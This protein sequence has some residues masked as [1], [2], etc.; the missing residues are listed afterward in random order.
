MSIEYFQSALFAAEMDA[1]W[2]NSVRSDKDQD[3]SET[4]K[5]QARDNI[6]AASFGSMLTILGHYN[7][8]EALQ[9]NGEQ[10]VGNA[11]SVGASVPYKLYIFDGMTESWLDY[12][13]IRS[14]DINARCVQNVAIAKSAWS[15]DTTA[16][17]G[18]SYKARITLADSTVDSFP[19]VVFESEQAFSGNFAPMSFAFA[20][21]LEVFAK[22]T[23][24]KDINIVTATVIVGGGAGKGITNASATIADKSI[25]RSMLANDA[26]SSTVKWVTTSP[27]TVIADDLEKTIV[28][29]GNLDTVQI[30]ISKS[31]FDALPTGWA[32]AFMQWSGANT[33]K[34]TITVDSSLYISKAGEKSGTLGGS[35]ITNNSRVMIVAKRIT[36]QSL[37]IFGIT[38]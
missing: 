29:D 13:Y 22:S 14:Q 31:L 28:F 26:L 3:L 17:S 5:A 6:G 34:L 11:Y 27:Y 4:Q 35:V 2:L 19:I 38:D 10:K 36:S 15:Q 7:T 16:L 12:G 8:V 9:A 23:P 21:Y 33:T 37:V 32:V 25:K 24:T 30:N 20:G 1:A 18:Y